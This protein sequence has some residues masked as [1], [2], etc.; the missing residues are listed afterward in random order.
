MQ[1]LNN[2]RPA[3]LCF[4]CA[5]EKNDDDSPLNF[6]DFRNMVLELFKRLVKKEMWNQDT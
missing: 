6:W 3:P 4:L 5:L 1:C 2:I